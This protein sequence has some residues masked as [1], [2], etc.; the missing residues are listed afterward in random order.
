MK[1]YVKL[2]TSENRGD[3]ATD[4]CEIHDVARG[5]TVE[6]LATRLLGRDSSIHGYEH[7]FEARDWIE[8]RP[9]MERK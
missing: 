1:L 4:V 6:G 3:H 8:I 9:V 5:E 7:G 2:H